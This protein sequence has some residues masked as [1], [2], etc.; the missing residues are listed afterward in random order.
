MVCGDGNS[1]RKKTKIFS[2]GWL[3]EVFHL[4]ELGSWQSRAFSVLRPLWDELKKLADANHHQFHEG[5]S[6]NSPSK[7]GNMKN[8]NNTRSKDC[9]IFLSFGYT[10]RA[11]SHSTEN[12]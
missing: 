5:L 1:R 6:R 8:I 10:N 2:M 4:E 11:K 12:H 3:S 9:A 7:G